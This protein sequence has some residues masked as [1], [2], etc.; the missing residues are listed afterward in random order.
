MNT[1]FEK[2][3]SVVNDYYPKVEYFESR[4]LKDTKNILH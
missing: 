2:Y 4:I 3:L 1:V